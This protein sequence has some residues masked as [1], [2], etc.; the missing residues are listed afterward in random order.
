M[1]AVV[2]AGFDIS[3]LLGSKFGGGGGGGG[4]GGW[5]S[6]GG[7]GGGGWSKFGGGGGGGGSSPTI[8]KVIKLYIFSFNFTIFYVVNLLD[9]YY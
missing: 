7:G 4:G 2:N 1:F 3:S 6:G 5:S 8:V 9:V